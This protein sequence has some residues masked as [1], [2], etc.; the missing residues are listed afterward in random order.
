MDHHDFGRRRGRSHGDVV[1][2]YVSVRMVMV[3]MSDVRIVM[4][5]MSD[6]VS[7]VS[8]MSGVVSLVV[9]HIST[10]LQDFRLRGKMKEI[11]RPVVF[12]EADTIL[13]EREIYR[14]IERKRERERETDL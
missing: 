12:R 7:N 5:V 10:S 13:G 4:V 6:V 2:M 1:H 14:E 9:L 8:T 11:I 3:M